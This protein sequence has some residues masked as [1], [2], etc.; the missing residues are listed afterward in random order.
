MPVQYVIVQAYVPDWSGSGNYPDQGLPPAGVGIWP[1]PGRPDQGLPVPPTIWPG[2][3]RPDQ[4]LPV[5]PTI[6]PGPGRPDQGLPVPPEIWPSPGRPDQGLPV[7]PGIWPG[8][9]QPSHPIAPGGPPPTIWPGPGRPDQGLPVPPTIWPSP[10][11]P[12]QGLPVPPTIWPSP[13]RPDQGLPSTPWTPE[14]PIVIPPETDMPDHPELPDLN[15]GNWI[16]VKDQGGVFKPAF[17]PWPLAVT[18]P[19]YNPE[20]PETGTP[21]EWVIIAYSGR[22]AWAWVPSPGSGNE[23]TVTPH[24][25]AAASASTS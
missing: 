8:Y 10:G 18:H 13:G 17:V 19:D 3:G 20:Y 24:K 21:G 11:R 25:K 14:H 4:G 12:D 9:G 22:A 16:Y 15:A 5:P 2:P 1:S 7:P 6:W 23:P